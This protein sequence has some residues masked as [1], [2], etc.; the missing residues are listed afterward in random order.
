[1]E[2]MTM[3]RTCPLGV[4]A[5]PA[6]LMARRSG[7]PNNSELPERSGKIRIQQPDAGKVRLC[8]AQHGEKTEEYGHLEQERQA[9]TQRV[10]AILLVHGHRLARHRLAGELVFLALVLILNLLQLWGDFEHLALALD[11]LH[12]DRDQGGAHHQGQPDDR[13][14][15]GEAG[16]RVHADRFEDGVESHQDDLDGPLDGPQKCVKERE[17]VHA[18]RLALSMAVREVKA[19]WGRNCGPAGCNDGRQRIRVVRPKLA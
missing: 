6:V 15:P 13:Q 18:C 14:H 11:L 8:I 3:T 9:R 4:G 12:E 16:V 5:S 17:D 7:A 1:M 10:R 19:V 2:A